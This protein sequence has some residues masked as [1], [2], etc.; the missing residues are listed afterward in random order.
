MAWV[1]DTLIIRGKEIPVK[2]GMMNQEPLRF[3][4]ENPRI[5]SIV[6]ADDKEPEQEHIQ[7]Q[8]LKM[9]HVK[10]LYQDIKANGGL[11]DPIIVREGTYEVL[12]GNSRLAAYRALAEK[13]D[14]IKWG[15]IK[16]QLLPQDIEDS[17]VFA[18]LGQYH[19][20]GKK[21]WLP[22]EQAGF[23][24]RRH[25]HH[26]KAKAVLG[27]ELGL[28]SRHVSQLIETYQFMIDHKD[29]NTN[30]WSFY[31]EYIRSTKIRKMRESYDGFD[32]TIVQK[33]KSEDIAKA[34]EVRDKLP[35]LASAP[36]KVVRKFL[37]GVVNLDEAVDL[38]EQSGGTDATYQKL[39]RFR[40]WLGQEETEAEILN[41]GSTARDKIRFEVG[42]LNARF[43]SLSRN[44]SNMG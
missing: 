34:V 20:K 30:R 22:Y 17:D 6:R 27:H 14:P 23:L 39:H 33:I 7:R 16:C 12:E 40:N 43:R 35:K 10:A 18:L 2:V 15:K 42:K 29:Y 24:Y 21:D 3:Y 13:D 28:G 32:D 26:N 31:W 37:D 8:L 9:E 11:I 4:P 5:Y 25:K 44:L 36:K 41:P 1:N 19:I 38:V